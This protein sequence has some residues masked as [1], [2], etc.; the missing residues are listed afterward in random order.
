MN[1][2]F[3]R[4]KTTNPIEYENIV[5][6]LQYDLHLLETEQTDEWNV[7]TYIYSL[8]QLIKPL[9]TNSNMKF[10]GLD[11]PQTMPSD[12]RVDYFYRPTYIAT[13]YVMKAVLLYPSLLD[14]KTFLDSE[15]EFTVDSVKEILASL[16]LASTGRKFNGAG[17]LKLS[18]CVSI[19]EKAG[20]AEF[21][22]K[23]P[24]ICPEFTNLFFDAKRFVENEEYNQSEDWYY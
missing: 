5:G 20:A 4:P 18:D 24:D 14:K 3:Y 10:L 6:K 16:M 22:D 8:S 21:L 9:E 12:A 7:Y 19:F 17:V 1:C 2:T 13:A 23:Y 11:N 15:L